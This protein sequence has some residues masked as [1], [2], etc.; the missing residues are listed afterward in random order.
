MQDN[1]ID[2][3]V[4]LAFDT[5]KYYGVGCSQKSRFRNNDRELGHPQLK[6]HSKQR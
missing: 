6:M 5:F 2:R 4:V 1:G 3:R